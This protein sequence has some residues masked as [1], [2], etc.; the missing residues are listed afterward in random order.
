MKDDIISVRLKKVNGKLIYTDKG[1]EAIHKAFVESLEE[2]Q[3]VE[4][5]FE[6]HGGNGT[7][8]QMSKIHPCIRKLANE[9]GMTFEAMKLEIKKRS[10]LVVNG[11][12]KSFADCSVEELSG[13]I[14][15][16]IETGDFVNINFRGK[17]PVNHPSAGSQTEA[18]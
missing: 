7:Y 5:F 17:L 6:A 12:A 11:E 1:M 14:Q 4:A 13:V 16:I 8:L 18:S 3:V 9:I 2:G 10:G 15:T